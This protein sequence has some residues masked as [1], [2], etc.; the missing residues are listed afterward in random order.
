[1][2]SS[3]AAKG[4]KRSLRKAKVLGTMKE[5]NILGIRAR[6]SPLNEVD[7]QLIQLASNLQLVLYREGDALLL[8]PVPKGSVIKSTRLFELN[9]SQ[10]PK[11]PSKNYR[12]FWRNFT[13]IGVGE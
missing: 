13:I 2:G 6:P 5:L 3:G 9:L 10:S 4:T 12:P 11:P 1:M 8:R 7:A